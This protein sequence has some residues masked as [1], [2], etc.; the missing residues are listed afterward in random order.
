MPPVSNDQVVFKLGLGGV[1]DLDQVSKSETRRSRWPVPGYLNFNQARS[2]KIAS[3]DPELL[4]D[5]AERRSRGEA[6]V[7]ADGIEADTQLVEQVRRETVRPIN[8]RIPDRL[9]TPLACARIA[10]FASSKRGLSQIHLRPAAK[11]PIFL[12]EEVVESQV[13]LVVIQVS[14]ALEKVVV[15]IERVGL[16]QWVILGEGEQRCGHRAGGIACGNKIIVRNGL[17]GIWPRGVNQLN[18]TGT[19]LAHSAAE[20]SAEVGA[21]MPEVSLACLRGEQL[22]S[23]RPGRDHPLSLVVGEEEEFVPHNWPADGSAELVVS[24]FRLFRPSGSTPSGRCLI[25]VERV[26]PEKFENVA[27]EGVGPRFEGRAHDATLVIAKFRRGVLGDQVEFLNG[28]DVGGVPG[29]VVLVFAIEDPVNQVG[30][31]LF[32]VSIDVG[33][34]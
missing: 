1:E 18:S 17:S 27:M 6:F 16:R 33:P 25:G 8:H 21:E 28:V 19:A 26:V 7:V 12:G 5:V 32:A 9:V 2:L 34:P 15:A 22:R 4:A 31:G 29:L 14:S 30:V 10:K 11:N 24:Q 23:G 13:A 3:R 20:A